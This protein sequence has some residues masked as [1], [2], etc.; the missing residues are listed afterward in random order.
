MD[1]GKVNR[2][3]PAASPVVA[4]VLQGLQVGGMERCAIQLAE[5]A[6]RSGYD[7]R[8]VLYDT[9]PDN[10]P[11]NF[12]NGNI[13]VAF[14]P[15]T[16]GIDATLPRRLAR[17]FREWKV[18]LVHARNQV[19]AIYSA[20]ANAM[21]PG[22]APHLLITF[23]TLPGKA[24][25]KAR[26]ASRWAARH[27]AK[28]IGVSDELASRVVTSGWASS[29]DTIWNAVDP[30][31][32]TPQGPTA[33]LKRRL[34]LSGD[35]LLIG[36]IAR[37]EHNKRQIDL[38]QAVRLLRQ[39]DPKVAL[40]FA[41]GGPDRTELEKLSH[42]DPAVWL[43]GQVDDVPALLRELDIFVLCSEHEGA[44]L[45]LLEAMSCAR[46]AVATSVGGMP[47][48][49]QDC[50]LLVPPRRPES[51]AEALERLCASA[52]LRGNLG[53]RARARVLDAFTI[54]REWEEYRQIYSTLL[55]GR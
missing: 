35:T 40:V 30:E 51:L 47:A 43:L 25:A 44:P 3:P 29:C 48:I 33:E 10:C 11:A 28:V 32:F 1:S 42:D 46:A 36:Q 53:E 26:L 5:C 21:M 6:R 54:R 15:R 16:S 22:K 4:T 45:A 37:L 13:P 49:L 55:N 20:A 14:L 23:D 38:L 18:D 39:R 8:L 12:T 34:G 31:Q 7:A 24:T 9:P 19:A 52:E 41:G 2:H 50:G 27:A 17:L